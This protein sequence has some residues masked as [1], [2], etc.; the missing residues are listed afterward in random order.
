MGPALVGIFLAIFK[1]TIVML[2]PILI[3]FVLGL[4]V[5]YFVDTDEVI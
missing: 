5:L 4:I 2:L 1:N 3:L